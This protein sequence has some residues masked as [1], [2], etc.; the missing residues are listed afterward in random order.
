MATPAS[1]G[2]EDPQCFTAGEGEPLPKTPKW[3][4]KLTPSALENAAKKSMIV[5]PSEGT[6]W[7]SQ[8]VEIKVK[9]F[10]APNMLNAICE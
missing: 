4:Q 10:D 2:G 7:S 6:A 3:E 9:H 1:R 5:K 8:T